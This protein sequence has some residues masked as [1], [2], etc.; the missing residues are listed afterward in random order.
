M[1]LGDSWK[2]RGNLTEI[3]AILGRKICKNI[4]KPLGSQFAT[5]AGCVGGV[6]RPDEVDFRGFY[7]NPRFIRDLSDFTVDPQISDQMF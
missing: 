6:R 5:F 4:I 1:I 2:N 7:K 3:L